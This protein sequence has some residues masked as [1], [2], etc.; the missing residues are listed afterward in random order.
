MDL[1]VAHM[2]PSI[3]RLEAAIKRADSMAY[4][5]DDQTA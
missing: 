3:E 2:A 5:F 1:D 4:T